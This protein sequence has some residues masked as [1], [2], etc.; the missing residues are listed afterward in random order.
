MLLVGRAGS[1][2]KCGWLQAEISGSE[3]R[4]D[5]VCIS[6]PPYRE[7]LW[8]LSNGYLQ[9]K[10]TESE[11]YHSLPPNANVENAWRFAST[12]PTPFS[13]RT[14]TYGS[15]HW[16][17]TRKKAVKERKKQIRKRSVWGERKQRTLLF[18]S[19]PYLSCL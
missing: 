17:R 3:L 18:V 6:T 8:A 13:A 9:L 12:S 10:L 2:S 1:G 5:H 19:S 15:G 14:R 4:Q 16:R 7:R 11:V